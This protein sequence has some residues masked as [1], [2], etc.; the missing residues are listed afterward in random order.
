[1][2]A[3]DTNILVRFFV[4]DDQIQATKARQLMAAEEGVYVAKTV[5]LEFAWVLSAVYSTPKDGLVRALTNLAGLE[6][7][8]IEDRP[9][10]EKAIALFRD[11]L[12]NFADALHACSSSSSASFATF[13]RK[14][15]SKARRLG[16]PI[17]V[18]A[19]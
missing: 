9:G 3:L 4:A 16:T 8:E 7:V 11:G 13:D 1:M 19:P 17:R 15:I 10:V 12:D 14:F 18:R 6:N 2:T 5:V